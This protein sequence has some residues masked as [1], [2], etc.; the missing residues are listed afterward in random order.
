MSRLLLYNNKIFSQIITCHI[1]ESQPYAHKSYYMVSGKIA[2]YVQNVSMG[3]QRNPKRMMN[4]RWNQLANLRVERES[5][6]IFEIKGTL[7]L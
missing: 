5:T 2:K 7:C 6:C 4:L 3:C 1:L